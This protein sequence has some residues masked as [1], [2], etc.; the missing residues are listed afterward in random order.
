MLVFAAWFLSDHRVVV[1]LT[2]FLAGA[3]DV[4]LEYWVS[5]GD[6]EKLNYAQIGRTA[7]RL[8]G[9]K[10]F[11]FEAVTESGS[12]SPRQDTPLPESYSSSRLGFRVQ[13]E[14]PAD[15]R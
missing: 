9:R 8:R 3:V 6:D 13:A 5:I 1:D 12:V 14:L 10:V 2:P 11:Q 15:E 4:E 7:P